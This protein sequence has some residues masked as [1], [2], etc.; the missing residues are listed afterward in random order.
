M[1]GSFPFVPDRGRAD[2]SLSNCPW[3]Q[4]DALLCESC[5]FPLS[6]SGRS[7][8]CNHC[9]N[10][11]GVYHV[12]TR[13]ESDSGEFLLWGYTLE[14]ASEEHAA[15]LIAN[16]PRFDDLPNCS[17]SKCVAYLE[18]DFDS[19]FFSWKDC[20]SVD[21][22]MHGR[23]QEFSDHLFWQLNE[24]GFTVTRMD[25]H[26]HCFEQIR[27][28]DKLIWDYYNQPDVMQNDLNPAVFFEESYFA[29][30]LDGFAPK[31]AFLIP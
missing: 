12:H 11:T 28:G 5:L 21:G 20:F 10:P 6:E 3:N 26:R 27:D 17:L 29:A 4:P 23:Y 9:E 16:A 7:L 25:T 18:E 31:G 24:S 8:F 19:F 14:A 15:A 2:E 13:T 22:F 1:T 30:L